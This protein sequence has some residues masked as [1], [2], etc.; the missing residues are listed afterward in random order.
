M[1][2]KSKLLELV[3]CLCLLGF[4]N[5]CSAI[6]SSNSTLLHSND[7][8]S[9]VGPPDSIQRRLSK[10]L[11]KSLNMTSNSTGGNNQF[12]RSSGK[13]EILEAGSS[14]RTRGDAR[15]L[16]R[17]PPA[18]SGPRFSD[19]VFNL[20]NSVRGHSGYDRPA[21]FNVVPGI[22]LVSHMP[23]PI[24]TFGN[25]N[26]G[27][28]APPPL[29]GGGGSYGGNPTSTVLT[30][31]PTGGGGAIFTT[32]TSMPDIIFPPAPGP[33]PGPVPAPGPGPTPAPGPTPIRPP[34]VTSVPIIGGGSGGG[35]GETGGGGGGSVL[36]PSPPPEEIFPPAPPPDEEEFLDA[37]GVGRRL[38]IS[39]GRAGGGV[40]RTRTR[41]VAPP[42]SRHHSSSRFSSHEAHSPPLPP[43]SPL[44][45]FERLHGGH[46]RRERLRDKVKQFKPFGEEAELLE[47]HTDELILDD[48]NIITGK[49]LIIKNLFNHHGCTE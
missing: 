11:F 7:S 29:P 31:R 49:F 40:V 45:G 5:I 22:S 37:E 2:L 44:T 13:V 32:T 43:P 36:P 18:S 17:G 19:T 8:T 15:V 4:P 20:R 1:F 46:V 48:P 14:L 16:K 38:K 28:P 27:P 47:P 6:D 30:Y 12:R 41:L 9:P 34:T 26:A 42:P 25:D 24:Y 10:D 39:T 35:G 3:M 33:D 21:S 23:P